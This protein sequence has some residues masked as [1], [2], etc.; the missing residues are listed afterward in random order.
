[1]QYSLLTVF[2]TLLPGYV[3]LMYVTY[4]IERGRIDIMS[5][6]LVAANGGKVAKTKIRYKA[7]LSYDQMK[8]Y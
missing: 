6:I 2:N 4:E 1:M 3:V 8:Q 5:E 7:L